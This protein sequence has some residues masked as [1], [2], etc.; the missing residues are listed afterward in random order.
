LQFAA[1]GFHINSITAARTLMLFSSYPFLLGFLPLSLI[2]MA[3]VGRRMR[4]RIILMLLVSLFF[5][6]WWDWRFLPLLIGSISVN[7]LLG[8]SIRRC[9]ARNRECAATVALTLGVTL[10]LLLLGGF[11]Y[12]HFL[13]ANINAVTAGDWTMVHLVLPLGISFWTFEQIGFLVDLR[14]GAHYRPEPLRYALFVLF[15]PR[16]VAGPILRYS[17]IE[18]QLAARETRD[19][20]PDLAAG[21][22]IFTIGLAKKAFLADGIAPFVASG[23]GAAQQGRM[24][25]L[26]AA[27][28]SALAY[29][30]QLYFDF[31]GYSDMAIGAARCFGIRFPANFNSPYQA[32][33]IIEF[34]RR[35]HMTLSRFLRDYLYI[36]LGGNRRGPV[37]RYVNLMLTMLL[38]GLW[39]GAAWTFVI[40]GGLHGLYLMVNHAWLKLRGPQAADMPRSIAGALTF[41]AVVIGWVF[42]RAADVSTAWRM[43]RGMAG[44]NGTA[45]PP[46]LLDRMG[47]PGMALRHFGVTAS[48]MLGGFAFTAMWVW[49]LGLLALAWLAPNTQQIME[50]AEPALGAIAGRAPSLLRWAPVPR[51]GLAIGAVAAVGLLSVTR[52]RE[53]LYWQF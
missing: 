40:W 27:W 35:W 41:V 16:L 51:W 21:L 9:V 28:G 18:P 46:A 14:R 48:S 39:H 30:C 1:R 19:T 6:A 2:G 8:S 22:S 43:L 26:F 12:L 7:F 17:E 11:K 44:L 45:M 3:L 4:N 52:G 33:S 24:L 15:F 10:N 36:A 25:D 37:R 42:F 20:L 5:Y 50:R 34:W 23:F 38:G 13:L 31:S 47:A 49:V 53:F 29:A 32:D